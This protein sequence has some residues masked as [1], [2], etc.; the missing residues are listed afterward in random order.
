M[1]DLRCTGV[2]CNS[3]TRSGSQERMTMSVIGASGSDSS[4]AHSR[5]SFSLM[6][7]PLT[8]T[9]I[10]PSRMPPYC[11]CIGTRLSASAGLPGNTSATMAPSSSRPRLRPHWFRTCRASN[12]KPSVNNLSRCLRE[13][14]LRMQHIH[15]IGQHVHTQAGPRIGA[16]LD[17]LIHYALDGVRRDCK[18]DAHIGSDAARRVNHR[19]HANQAAMRIE[20]RATAVARVDGGIR[21]HTILDWSAARTLDVTPKCGDDAGG[22]C[23]VETK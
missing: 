23:P 1:S 6:L 18:A 14:S 16:E 12:R 8:A 11:R 4:T 7:F 19:V 15:L 13:Y 5:S 17:Y 9:I 2:I 22:E 10:S 20:E 21:L 3:S